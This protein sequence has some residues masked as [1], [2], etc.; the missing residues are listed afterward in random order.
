MSFLPTT[1]Q[2]AMRWT[3]LGILPP[4]SLIEIK[5]QKGAPVVA[6][7][8]I[9]ADG[10]L[11]GQMVIDHL[12]GHGQQLAL[13]AIATFHPGLVADARFPLVTAGWCIAGRSLG[14]FPAL[15][16]DILPPPEQAAEQGNLAVG[17]EK[18]WGW[19]GDWFRDG[20]FFPGD[21]VPGQQDLEAG[22]LLAQPP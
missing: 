4:V 21:T 11:P 16:I 14:R 18:G 6:Q 3:R 7:E 2:T 20:R 15:R 10:L 1:I 5:R 12:I 22:I 19:C 17:G 13:V 8:R 9:D